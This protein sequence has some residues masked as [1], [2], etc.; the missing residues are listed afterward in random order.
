MVTVKIARDVRELLRDYAVDGESVDMTVNRL[1][2]DVEECLNSDVDFG[3]DSIN[4]NVSRDTMVRIKSFKVR[5]DEPY[6]RIL[7]RALVVAD[8]SKSG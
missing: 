3:K 1:L 7:H 5:D 6:G 2:D 8:E 4:I